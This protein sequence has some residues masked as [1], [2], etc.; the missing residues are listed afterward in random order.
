[1]FVY[2]IAVPPPGDTEELDTGSGDEGG[3]CESD[4]DDPG[5]EVG[6]G[7]SER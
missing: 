6:G 3:G 7:R 5:G 2:C 4:A 1:M